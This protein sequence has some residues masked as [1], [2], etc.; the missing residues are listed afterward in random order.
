MAVA[1]PGPGTPDGPAEVDARPA[2]ANRPL[3]GGHRDLDR[4]FDDVLDHSVALFGADKAGLWRVEDADHPFRLAAHRGLGPAFLAVVAEVER[5]S[6]AAGWRAVA[7]RRAIVVQRPWS[8]AIP[9]ELAARYDEEG[10]G[11][12]CLVPVTYLDEPLGLLALYH[13]GPHAWAAT[14]LDLLKSFA[15]QVA[16]ALQNARLYASI[17]LF[18]ARLDAIQ[19]LAAR[20][21]RLHDPTKIGQAIVAEVRG[22][23]E[24]DTARVYRVDHAAGTCEP[25]AFGGIFLGVPDP[26]VEVLRVPIGT[27]LTGWVAAHNTAVRV[28]DARTDPRRLVVGPDEEPESMLLVPMTFEDVVRGVVV[29]SKKGADRYVEDDLATLRIFAGFAAQA[30]VNA[31]NI[32]RLRVQQQEL[33]HRLA[34]QRALLDVNETLLGAGDPTLVLERIADGLRSVVRYDNLTIYRIDRERGVRTAVLA[35]D[36][37]A[38]VILAEEIPTGLGLTGWATGHGEPLLANDAH[39]DPRAVNI[40][41][42]PVE[43]ESLI[44]VPLRVGGN[45][46]GTLNVGR[47]GAAEAHFA[48]DEFELVKLFA[49]QASTALQTAEALHAA[50]LRAERDALT[51]LR[52]H[53]AF[54]A[55][56]EGLLAGIRDGGPAAFVLLM[57]DLDG[58]KSFND[59]RGHPAGDRLLRQ[60]ADALTAHVRAEDRVFRYGGDE[61]AVLLP[62]VPRAEAR[63]IADRLAAA[64]DEIGSREDGPH[65]TVSIGVAACPADGTSKDELVMLADAELYLEKA[66]RRKVRG[67][68]GGAAAGRGAEYLAAIHETTSALMGR[69]DPTELLETIVAR[70]ATLAGTPSGYLYLLDRDTDV[71][72][73]TVGLG[74]FR[75][76]VGHEVARGV[77]VGG[78]VLAT[79]EPICI[80]D[81][82]TWPGRAPGLGDLGRLGSV[83]GAPL[84]AGTEVIGVIGL[85][86][87]DTG[88]VFDETD[89]AGLSRFAQLAS[90]AMEN[91]RLHATARAELAA[92]ARSED[93]LRASTERLRRLA[94]ASFEAL[95]IHRDGRILEVNSAFADLFGRASEEVLGSP[96]VSL[97]PE[98]ARAAV[99]LQ[100]AVDNETPYETDALLADGSEA[101][102]ELIGRTVPYPDDVPARATAIRDIRERRAIQERLARQSFYDTLTGLPNRSLFMD[103]ATHALGW[104]HPDEATPLAV[105]LFDL[106]RFKVINESLGHAVGD[107]L[108]AAVGRRLADVL[109]PA[110]TLARLG[111]DEFAV[112]VDGLAGEA[113][114]EGL[115][116]RMIEALASPFVVEGRDTYVAAS[117]GVAMSRAGGQSAADLLREAEIALYRAKA[118]AS[119]RVAMFHPR[120]S[121]SSMDRLELELDLRLAIERDE[122]RVHYQPLVDLGTGRTLG[123]EA[124]VRWEHPTRGLLGP[125]SFIPL[126]EETGLILAIDDVV[127][128]EACRQARAWQRADPRLAD[129]VVAVNLSAR[130]FARPDLAARIAAVLA[131]TGLPPAALELEITESL[132]MSDAEATGVTLRA[133]H[134]LGVRVALDDFG[135]GYS[136]LAY[137]SQL[138]LDVIKID[139]SFVAGLHGSP[140]NLA[141]V[142]AVVG[143]AQG[144]GIA[145]TAEGI[146]RDDQLAALRDLGCDRGQGFLFARP[147]SAAETGRVL[148]A[149]VAAAH[150]AGAE[151]AEA[152]A[153]GTGA[154]AAVAAA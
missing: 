54:Q 118:D 58:F 86:A 78:R 110:D 85:T 8:G 1:L 61:F 14:E 152:V 3:P 74:V 117:V 24:S 82:D 77:G 108:L 87:G 68:A 66:A 93:E 101:A 51:G 115:A 60:V 20:L 47:M 44:V 119:D 129:L 27:G 73:L 21:N 13:A 128:A 103:R 140:A 138:P 2:E 69:H 37:Y 43:P 53:G 38:E 149:G 81:Y 130:Q 19:D 153:G 79:G 26:A 32:G 147:T 12:I 122:L 56:L 106:D 63:V 4:I 133:L 6:P 134:E 42:T 109:R 97:F 100:L 131:E 123:H 113:A 112:L 145:V 45:V 76:L 18:A 146:E 124:L 148:L 11:T 80:Q 91:A 95:V 35:R 70:A 72:H 104:A 25:I 52:D 116:R 55:D 22:L 99:A 90:V 111:G 39:L 29:V 75:G 84:T 23:F 143:L 92:R 107:Q 9:S 41:G 40:P 150:A 57:L 142:R 15:D 89:V 144:L 105:L 127:L 5:G 7:E 98:S 33:E 125:L 136:S 141:I 135:T 88:R 31:E 151:A 59:G 102:V 83:V 36:R 139:R 94:D 10:F 71:L 67:V 114:A 50:A 65:V 30:L 49:G 126:A 120:M 132:A 28:A 62:D 96:V 121:A 154:R 16:A 34:S 17:R 46:I 137:L 64:V 48:P